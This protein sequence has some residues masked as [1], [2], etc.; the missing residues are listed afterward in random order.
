MFAVE[1]PRMISGE[2]LAELNL[3]CAGAKEMAECGSVYIFLP[4]LTLPGGCTPRQIDALLRLSS[5]NTDYPTR[6]FMSQMVTSTTPRNWNAKNVVILQKNWFA[7]SW[8]DVPNEG[9]P[10]EVVAQHLSALQ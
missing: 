7:Y 1:A 10:I 5:T 6:L 4:A 3:I 9:R 8:K 2:H